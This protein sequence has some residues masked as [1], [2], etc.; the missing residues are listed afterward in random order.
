MIKSL[1]HKYNIFYLFIILLYLLNIVLI[2]FLYKNQGCNRHRDMLSFLDV[3]QGD[4]IYI[5]NKSGQSILIDTGNKDSEVLKQIQTVKRCYKI[6]I[7]YLILTH[8]DQDHIGEASRLI[9]KGLVDHVVHNGFLDIDQ[10]EESQTENDLE[11][12]IKDKKIQ[13]QNM[14]LNPILDFKDF[15]IHFLFPID[16]IYKYKNKKTKVDDN[17]FSI[18]V[19][20]NHVDKS[21]ILTGDAPI[22]VEKEIIDKYDDLTLKSDVLKLGHHGSKNSSSIDFLREVDAEDYTISASK[23]NKY[24]HPNEETLNRIKSLNKKDSRIR[25]TSLEGNIV[26]ILD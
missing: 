13:T 2:I 20:I 6:H 12:I 10:P 7:D 21:F 3:G 17:D 24:N 5:E 14:M 4:A 25:E 19:K 1:Y 26:Y 22:K 16:Q 11:D 15:D 8:P 18:I 9:Q 23:D